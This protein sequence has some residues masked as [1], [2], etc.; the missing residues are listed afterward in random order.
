V[1][2]YSELQERRTEDERPTHWRP[3]EYFITRMTHLTRAV[4]PHQQAINL[5][6]LPSIPFPPSVPGILSLLHPTHQKWGSRNLCPGTALQPA[7]TCP[8]ST[9]ARTA[10]MYELSVRHAGP[11]GR[12]ERYRMKADTRQRQPAATQ[13]QP[14][15]LVP[16]CARTRPSLTMRRHHILANRQLRSRLCACMTATARFVPSLFAYLPVCLLAT[17]PSRDEVL[18]SG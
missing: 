12:G 13:S 6:A 7:K 17:H 5:D 14:R 4:S 8:T 15:A 3:E 10:G 2:R 9:D 11:W 18:I 1:K 16:T